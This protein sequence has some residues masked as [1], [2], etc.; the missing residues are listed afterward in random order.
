M[1]Q[2]VTQQMGGMNL[3]QPVAG[4]PPI[5][6]QAP[7]ATQPPQPAYA[8]PSAHQPTQMQQQA[9]AAGAAGA[10]GRA[11]RLD[12]RTLPNPTKIQQPKHKVIYSVAHSNDLAHQP[13]APPFAHHKYISSDRGSCTPR[14]MRSTIYNIPTT[15]DILNTSHIPLGVAVQPLA[16]VGFDE[17][18]VPIVNLQPSGPLRCRRCAAYINPFVRFVEAGRRYV[19]ALCGAGNEVPDEYFS[20]IEVSGQR[21]DLAERV[22]LWRGTVDFVAPPEL[23]NAARVNTKPVFLF[24][25]DVSAVA[26]GCGLVKSFGNAVKQILAQALADDPDTKVGFIT[27]DKGIHFWRLG[28]ESLQKVVLPDVKSVFTP[29]PSDAFIANYATNKARIDEWLDRVPSMFSKTDI[30]DSAFGAAVNAAMLSFGTTGGR[31]IALQASLPNVGPG[32]LK[33]RDTDPAVHTTM[34]SNERERQLLLPQSKFWRELATECA[35]RVVCIDLFVAAQ[36]YC[37]LA[38]ISLLPGLTGGSTSYV[39]NFHVEKHEER[40]YRD[41]ERMLTRNHGSD[42]VLRVRTSE[43]IAVDSYDGHFR[44]GP[45]GEVELA[46]VD[47]DSTFFVNLKYDDNIPEKN[48]AAIQAA[49]LYTSRDGQRLIRVH[50]LSL[51]TSNKLSDVFKAADIDTVLA[52]FVRRAIAELPQKKLSE[53]RTKLT[54]N[55]VDLLAAYRKHCAKSSSDAQLI[56]PDALK[57]LPV[58]L[59]SV[60]KHPLLCNSQAPLQDG[61]V[62]IA[63]L[64]SYFMSYYSNLSL[65]HLAPSLYAKLYHLNPVMH[66]IDNGGEVGDTSSDSSDEDDSDDDEDN[67]GRKKSKRT[68]V[69]TEDYFGGFWMPPTIRLSTTELEK[70]G[71]YLLDDATHIYLGACLSWD[72]F[73]WVF[74]FLRAK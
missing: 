22:E 20:P 5:N 21:R 52:T 36:G 67:G 12:P 51:K 73:V 46:G 48:D 66:A 64:R 47:A 54:E 68:I 29:L 30:R 35:K 11:K 1:M 7:V 62:S 60:L 57:T 53:I 10:A 15:K 37:D 74:S 41:L 34:G 70:Q 14:F 71:I 69:G 56:L 26:V 58:Y 43:G 4:P 28:K 45:Q 63:D 23:V 3:A 9:Q 13:T 72:F 18:E 25:L 24:L 27:Y 65:E 16:D 39:P 33:P 49:M 6:Y 8:P 19:C 50:T 38:T 2:P 17:S 55:A 44:L 40:L 59:L 31:I 42:A 32:A 61:I